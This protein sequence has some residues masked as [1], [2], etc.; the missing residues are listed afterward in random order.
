[1][2]LHRLLPIVILLLAFFLRVV[3]IDRIPPGLSHDEAYNGVTAMQ[4]LDGQ[5]LIF[6]EI[7]K[8][9]EPLII[10]LEALAFYAF[11]IGPVPMRLVNV[12]CGLLTVALVYPL[13]KRLFNRRVALLAMTGLAVS[14]WAIFTSRLALRAVILPPLLMLTLYFLWRGL[15]SSQKSVASSQ[16]LL[17]NLQPSNLKPSIFHLPSSIFFA[18]SGLAAGATMYTYLSSRFVPLLLLAVFAYQLLR[19]QVTRGHWL[20]LLLLFLLW[21]ILF[22]PLAVYFWQHAASFT[23]RSSQ[24]S[25]LPYALNGDFGPLLRHT[26]RTLGM[27]TFHGDETDRY[28]LD[29][30]P[31][32]DW[33]NG[34]LFYLGLGLTLLRLRQPVNLAGPAALLLLWFFFMLLPGFITDDSPHFL[35]TIGAMPVAYLFWAIGLDWVGQRVEEA[36]RRRGEDARSRLTPHASRLTLYPLRFILH[37][38]SFILLLLLHSGYDYFIRWANAA[39][40]RTIYGADIAEVARYVNATRDEGLAAISAEYYRDLDPFRFSLHSYGR[41]PF[42][43]WFDG[44]QSLAFPPPESDLSPRYIFPRSAPPAEL[45][46]PFL[47]PAPAESGQE[48]RL[49]HLPPA[50]VLRQAETALFSPQNKVG[51][52]VNDDLILSA[53]QLLGSV[54]S[55][56]K[57]QVVLAWQAR[58]ALPP[59]ADYTFLVQLQDN[60]GHIWAAA[61]GNGYPAGA[62]QPGVQGLQLLLLRL[63]G[64]LPPRPYTLTAQVIDRRSGQALPVASDERAI[65][66]GSIMGQ[67]AK[68]PRLLDP[69]KLPNP[70]QVVQSNGLAAELALRGYDLNN[71]HVR[72]GEELALTLHW[73]VLQSP[74]QDY[75]L[76]FSLTNEQGET[77][78]RWPALPPINGEWPTRQ[79]PADYWVQDRFDLPLATDVPPGQFRLRAAWV[80]EETPSV[81]AAVSGELWPG[82]DLGQVIVTSNQ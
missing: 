53:Y 11:G 81:P 40:A 1:M 56:G 38:S 70:M 82:F 21:A 61:D 29:G 76:Q 6:F 8:G 41:P 28:N 35:R 45:W 7:N 54:T 46:Q 39:E 5:R 59:D 33:L 78:Y 47:Q 51:V 32:F 72:P 27:F 60:Q 14:F 23:E 13:A 36:K 9:I 30:R 75:R 26:G 74:P 77:L 58:R 17:S 19:R 52:K 10:Y 44:R 80:A 66:L 42:V 63:P 69:A 15:V 43:I 22:A 18:L 49:Y 73:Q 31:V 16:K 4:A 64:D 37:P 12:I 67:L 79:W 55:G 65:R 50:P 3:A 2:N 20:G 24:V 48:Y 57:F 25:T 34:L 62:W 71:S 68:T